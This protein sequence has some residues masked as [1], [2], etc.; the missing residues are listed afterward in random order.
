[1]GIENAAATHIQ[2]HARGE[3]ASKREMNAN[4]ARMDIARA[5][6]PHN[7]L[8]PFARPIKHSQTDLG[9]TEKQMMLLG[10]NREALQ[11]GDGRT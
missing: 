3:Q 2:K 7:A 8:H 9:P 4:Q 10:L 5:E 6:E 1:M 11:A